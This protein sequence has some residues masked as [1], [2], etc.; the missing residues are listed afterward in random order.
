[1]V[2]PTEEPSSGSFFGPKISNAIKTS[3]INSYQ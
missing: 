3:G 2:L 1:M